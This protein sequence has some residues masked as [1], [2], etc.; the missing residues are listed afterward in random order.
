MGFL[1]DLGISTAISKAVPG[2]IG[3]AGAALGLPDVVTSAAQQVI[4]GLISG[5]QVSSALKAVAMTNPVM[6]LPMAVSAYALGGGAPMGSPT[7]AQWP[8]LAEAPG[9]GGLPVAMRAAA[10]TA[11]A[12]T[13]KAKVT[14]LV[15]GPDGVWRPAKRYRRMNPLNPHAL[16]RGMRRV[17]AFAHIARKVITFTQHH[18]FKHKFPHRRHKKK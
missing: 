18:K 15:L 5:G 1:D 3:Q 12:R 7:S 16:F 4:P 13:R 17:Q 9:P 8:G 2:L 10:G 14:R 6:A 11:V